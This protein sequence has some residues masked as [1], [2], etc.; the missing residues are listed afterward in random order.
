MGYPA[1]FKFHIISDDLKTMP[2][3][4]RPDLL[5]LVFFAMFAADRVGVATT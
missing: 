1:V 5:A 4:K 3:E 2:E